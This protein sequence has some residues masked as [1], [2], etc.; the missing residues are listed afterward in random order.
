MHGQGVVSTV[1]VKYTIT[2]ERHMTFHH[3]IYTT[4]LH[5]VVRILEI[6]V[7][8]MCYIHVTRIIVLAAEV[9]LKLIY[10]KPT[11]VQ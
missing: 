8:T 3:F 11:I 5:H 6:R 9:Q 7:W 4:N 2:R 1:R 10:F